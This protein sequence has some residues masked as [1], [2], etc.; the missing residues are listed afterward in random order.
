MNS[1]TGLYV[2]IISQ[3]NAQCVYCYNEENVL[4]NNDKIES[5]LFEKIVTTAKDFGVSRITISGGEPMLHDGLCEI[6]D[7]AYGKEI[8]IKIITNF[9]IYNKQVYNLLC[10]YSIDLQITLDGHTSHFHNSTRGDGTFEKIVQN[11]KILLELGY[12]GNLLIRVNLHKNNYQYIEEIINCAKRHGASEVSLALVSLVGAGKRFEGLID[13]HHDDDIL[14]TIKNK[15]EEINAMEERVKV[16]SG[17]LEIIDFSAGCPYYGKENIS[18]AFR[19]SADGYVYPCQAFL[20]KI[21]NLGNIKH[22]PL[23]AILK[24]KKL[25]QFKTL[26]SLRKNFIPECQNCAYKNMCTTGCPADGY[27]KNGNIFSLF[28]ECD[29]RKRFFSTNIAQIL[30]KEV[31]LK[32]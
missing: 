20:D 19:I 9:T 6:L 12:K 8:G 27:I 4:Y 32:I 24:G 31:T 29:K 22:E 28:G 11:L 7:Y 21:F 15:I 13:R 5:A 14:N 10:K 26:L 1:L 2:E 18:C 30:D 3:C 23:E 17:A 16:N 25:E